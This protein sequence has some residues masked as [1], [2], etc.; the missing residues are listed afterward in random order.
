MS[1][2][3]TMPNKLHYRNQFKGHRLSYEMKAELRA[4]IR[5]IGHWAGAR[6]L[7]N[8]GVNFE[9]AHEIVLGYRPRLPGLTDTLSGGTHAS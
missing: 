3:H 1:A 2:T 4:K 6:W 9:D 7:K 8:Q 5:C